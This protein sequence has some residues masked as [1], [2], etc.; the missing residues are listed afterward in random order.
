MTGRI[1][2]MSPRSLARIAGV[3]YLLT[4]LTGIFAQG[5]VSGSIVVDGDAAT[6]ATNILAHRDLF[7]LGFAVYLVE[8]ACQVVMTA[9]FYELLKPAGRSV[10]LIAAYLGLVGCA[11]KTFSRV[12]FITPLFVLG[13][14]HYLSVFSTEQLQA[15]ALLFLNVN[16]QGAGIALVFFGF[17][18]LLNGYLVI[19]STF[20]PRILGVL[21][22]LGGVGWL[23]FLYPPLGY[24]LFP[25]IALLGL[26]G[27]GAKIL[28]LIVFGVNEERWKAQAS[29]ADSSLLT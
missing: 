11:I 19:R 29:A 9:L 16:D 3:F 2:E 18:A 7:Q 15:L 23:A 27:S 6:T 24:R 21:G 4:I 20:L 13:G 5:F 10:S 17:Y 12:F 1:A 25:I 14:S 22:I 28:W 8:M 26:L